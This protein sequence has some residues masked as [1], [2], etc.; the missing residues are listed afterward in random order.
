MNDKVIIQKPDYLA[1]RAATKNGSRFRYPGQSF[2]VQPVILEDGEET[3]AISVRE[4]TVGDA[5][6]RAADY[7]NGF[8]NDGKTVLSLDPTIV[9]DYQALLIKAIC[10]SCL[11]PMDWAMAKNG[12]S[13]KFCVAMCCGMMYGMVPEQVRVISVP[14]ASAN[15]PIRE[16]LSSELADADFLKE[17]EQM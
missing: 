14:I 8:L 2:W 16:E 9:Y 17:L 7:I 12:E 13:D 3:L 10:P 1:G 11:R 4:F 5:A 15:N 6:E